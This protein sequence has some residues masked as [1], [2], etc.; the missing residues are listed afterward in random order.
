MASISFKYYDELSQLSDNEM[1][2]LGLV[3][4]IAREMLT[5]IGGLEFG[6][7]LT[8][9]MSD[10]IC[11]C[12]VRTL[13]SQTGLDNTTIS[14]MKK[15]QNLNK[16]NVVSA[17]LGIHIPSRVSRK[18]LQLAEITLDVTLP[19]KKGEENDIYSRI[20]HLNWAMDYSDTY[21]ELKIDGYEYLIH[22]PPL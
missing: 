17:C 18:L 14:N 21:D 13:K 9:L 2:K 19:G 3:S 22:Q 15:G 11:R 5:A 10:N 12:S 1:L 20:L 8:K 4:E 16:S 6:D 7:A